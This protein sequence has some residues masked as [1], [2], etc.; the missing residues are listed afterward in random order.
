MFGATHTC[1]IRLGDTRVASRPRESGHTLLELL[2][3]LLVMALAAGVAAGS[4]VHTMPDM[5]AAI[6]ARLWEGG[7]AA[8]QLN[9]IWGGSPV[10]LVASDGGLALS[11]SPGTLGYVPPLG[12]PAVPFANV[13]RWMKGGA[14]GVRFLPVFGSPDGAGSLYFGV[15]GS[16][17][18]VT[19]RLESGLTKRTSW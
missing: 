9:A 1:H 17:Q 3:T 12:R 13:T 5:E 15:Q 6:A 7:A 4:L 19:L 8:A 16:G 11:G 18:R 2:L 14:V 10:D